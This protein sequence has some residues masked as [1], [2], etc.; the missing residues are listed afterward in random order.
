MNKLIKK[1]E[2]VKDKTVK[3][4]KV[5]IKLKLILSH[6]VIGIVP[7]LIVVILILNNAEAGIIEEV[8]V[9]TLNLANKTS[10]NLNMLTDAIVSTGKS[11]SVDNK[12]LNVVA[13]SKDDYENQFQFVSERMDIIDPLFRNI[14]LTNRAV[15]TIVFIKENEIISSNK[16][17]YLDSD[18]F[19]DEFFSRPYVQSLQG[20]ASKW[21]YDAFNTDSIFMIRRVRSVI[22]DIGVLMFEINPEYFTNNLEFDELEEGIDVY[23]TNENGNIIM[24]NII[25][26]DG[27][28]LALFTEITNNIASNEIDN[29]EPLE[30]TGVFTSLNNADVESL[31]SY[32]ELDNGWYYIQ[33]Q[34][35]QML[36]GSIDTLKTI[37]IIFFIVA[38][39]FAVFAG[40]FMAL[41]ITAPINYIKKL[42]KLLEQGDLTVKSN[43]VGQYE[44]GQLSSSFNQMV[45]NISLLIKDTKKTAT[46]VSSDSNNL[47][48]I[49][50][51]SASAS[52]EIMIAI[53]AL[54]TGSMEQAK[55]ADKT[56]TVINELATKIKET[57]LT[58]KSVTKSATRT[59]EVSSH[60]TTT[61]EELNNTTQ[62]SIQL[63][64]NIKSDMK[65]L[66]KRFEEIIS[67]V[68]MIDGISS[69]T[70]LLALN[71]AIEAARAGE[72]G[73]GFAVVA[74]EVRKLAEQSSDATKKISTIVNGIY[75][76][77]TK[78]EK[79]IE[80]SEEVFVEQE[81]AVKNTDKTFKTIVADMDTI[82]IEINNVSKVLSS[83]DAIQSEAID[84]TASIASIA[85]ESAAA[86]QQVLATGEEQSAN[87]DSLSNMSENL[88][89]I[90]QNLNESIEGFRVE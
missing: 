28:D 39:I 61:I 75:E 2:K 33:V 44:I 85:E 4:E 47:N 21:F 11:V 20:S 1:N 55:D 10:I 48:M 6:I 26:E 19:S 37:S 41:S 90:I 8:E 65:D 62:N 42:L 52:K 40:V 32:S 50:K 16:V 27:T 87:A 83:L 3:H 57:E 18:T 89:E 43:I 86:V 15:K 30:K 72:A 34:P 67:I 71:A 77:T 17:T 64:N 35:T 56:T 73:K 81:L 9:T 78:T 60:A 46:E 49:A 7:M 45:G 14:Q 36:L 68:G 80:N 54:A 25:E 53:E 82:S 13:K 22:A 51:Q 76:A 23:I 5:S 24:S 31:V 29:E 69:Q 63:S 59:R 88:G 79:M 84:A 12:A 70:N 58:F 74:D 66:V 38:A